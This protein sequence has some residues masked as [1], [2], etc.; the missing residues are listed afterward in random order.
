MRYLWLLFVIYSAFY[1]SWLRAADIDDLITQSQKLELAKEPV[2]L[3]LLHYKKE[4]LFRQTLSQVDDEDFFLASEGKIRP[5]LELEADIRAFFAASGPGHAQCLFPARWFWLKKQLDLSVSQYDVPCP[6]FEAW[7]KK[8]ESDTLTLIFPA[9]YLNNP[10]SAFGHTFLRF[11]NKN[12]ALLSY[13]L[14]YAAE[15]DPEDSF[16]VFAYKG[17]FGGYSGVFASRQYYKTLESYTNIENRDIW[18]YRLNY[19]PEEIRQLVRHIWEV[20]GIQFDYF[21]FRENCSYRLLALLDTI[22]PDSQ[23]TTGNAFSLYALPVDTVRALDEAGMIVDK[24]YRPSLAS[25]L[26]NGFESLDSEQ[27]KTIIEITQ[28]ETPLQELMQQV[29]DEQQ[30]ITVLDQAYTWLQFRGEAKSARAEEI[31][32]YRSQL[33]AK[34]EKKQPALPP[35]PEDGHKSARITIGAGKR[36][37]QSFV[38]FVLRP[39][40]HDLVDSPLGYVKGAEI[41][42][43]DTQFRWF[44]DNDVLRLESLRFL[45]IISLSPLTRWYK[46]I[47]WQLDLRLDRVQFTAENA[48]M[49]FVTRGGAGFSKKMFSSNVFA[50]AMFEAGASDKYEKGYSTL[51]GVQIGASILFTG[52]QVLMTAESDNAFSGFEL[53]KDIVATE[54]QFNLA[55][56]TALRFIYKKTRYDDFDDTD[57]SLR[58]QRYF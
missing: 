6:T 30:R 35:A 43:M 14:N 8:I 13:T 49:V 1:V 29:E 51:A 3:A 2:W 15:H 55:G 44:P 34:E 38:D 20:M 56:N 9:M 23:L 50:M 25:Q 28:A 26:K 46:S 24:Q 12:S 31:L 5:Q 27:K 57:W 53:D 33:P 39:G 7:M 32:V 52:G 48:D 36:Q 16:P 54:L 37:Q 40:F 45:N 4:T 17:I 11:D 42:V 47:S 18:E 19:S 41:N 22:R 21:F 10:G 58:L